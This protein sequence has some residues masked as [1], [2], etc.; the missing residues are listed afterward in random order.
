MYIDKFSSL[1]CFLHGHKCQKEHAESHKS[2][3]L[4][5]HGGLQQGKEGNVRA[6]LFAPLSC[7]YKVVAVEADERQ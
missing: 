2:S 7:L 4:V 1:F 3:H 6:V 5:R